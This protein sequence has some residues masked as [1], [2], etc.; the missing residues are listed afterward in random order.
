[1]NR[2]DSPKKQ[3]VPFAVNG[4]RENLL[5]TTP[6]GD[7][8]ASYN[9]GFPPVTMILKAA[10][11]LPPKGQDMNQIL[12]ELSALSRWFSTGALNYFDSTFSA[13]IG[14]YPK[15]ALVVSND[16]STIYI[17]TIDANTNNPNSV[18]TGWK[19]LPNYLGLTDSNGYAGRLINVV[20]ITSSSTYTPSAGTKKII[21]E[22]CGGGGGGGAALAT[23]V[24]QSSVGGGGF[25]GDYVKTP[26]L[27][28]ATYA[29]VIGSPGSG[30]DGTSSAT[31][32][33]V[34]TVGSIITCRGGPGG[35]VGAA[36]STSATG[37]TSGGFVGTL[38]APANSVVIPGNLG[39][40]GFIVNPGSASGQTGGTGGSTPLG[41]GG[42]GQQSAA[43][44]S[45]QS[46][47]YG[48]GGAGG[49]NQASSTIKS[50]GS[51]VQGVVIIWEYA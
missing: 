25:S 19:K 24:S 2:S 50:G 1:M 31:A 4:Q 21:I 44:N 46:N 35:S 11:G 10:G 43:G 27:D 47:S 14:G 34:T 51:G 41:R 30:G 20:T 40:R 42:E 3:P 8:T 45:P 26:L 36:S 37:N 5:T 17:S 39:V 33:G 32:G 6:A 48:C 15:D 29:I 23:G 12:F 38:T 16:D 49:A 13:A 28:A 18:T 22:A 7:N 9:S